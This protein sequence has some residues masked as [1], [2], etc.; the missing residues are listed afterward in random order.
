MAN[1]PSR[2]QVPFFI[3]LMLV[4]GILGA[5]F[6][7]PPAGKRVRKQN[8]VME[9]PP[10]T[11]EVKEVETPALAPLAATPTPGAVKK[12]Q[13]P[14]S[15]E[16]AVAAP[17]PPVSADQAA[18]EKTVASWK[19]LGF[20]SLGD[21]RRGHFSRGDREEDAFTAWEGQDVEGIRVASLKPGEAELRLG[22]GRVLLAI[23]K[24]EPKPEKVEQ[25]GGKPPAP[26][27]P[28]TPGAP[29]PEGGPGP[30][31]RPQPGGPG[32]VRPGP[33]GPPPVENA[34]NETAFR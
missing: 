23:Y 16:P 13:G 3:W 14:A 6:A 32:Q 2:G 24:E 10:P 19:Y 26:G 17:A 11:P 4:A 15:P 33:G 9:V 31:G 27:A 28:G 20:L 7:W 22:Q 12:D 5:L 18:L 1:Q 34:R 8:V 25:P 21:K 30:G 29:G